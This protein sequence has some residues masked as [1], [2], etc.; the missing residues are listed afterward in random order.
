MIQL[1]ENNAELQEYIPVNTGFS[2]DFLEADID[3][4]LRKYILPYLSRSQFDETFAYQGANQEKQDELLA[5]VKKSTAL[6][7]MHLYM[8]Q[9]KV[10]IDGDSI[11]YSV[12]REKQASA[13]DKRELSDSFLWKG[14]EA[15]EDMLTFLEENDDVFATW[16]GSAGYTKFTDHFVRTATEMKVIE[17]SRL[18][19]L[20]LLPAIEMV[21][22]D[23]AEV[24]PETAF[25]TLKSREFGNDAEQK[26]LWESLLV[27]YVQVIVS[28]RALAMG[29]SQMV[30]HLTKDGK[31]AAFNNTAANMTKGY[32]QLSEARIGQLKG[33]LN[34]QA[35]KRL[36][37]MNQFI[38]DNAELFGYEA[39]ESHNSQPFVNRETH[40]SKF[41][42]SFK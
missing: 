5:L 27:D 10:S 24:L 26:K 33:D 32:L 17:D 2:L 37:R 28:R 35:D 30:V 6:L 22:F 41:F 31:L 19:F 9:A 18:V 8:P 34:Q 20:R 3:S 21:E 42:G 14:L 29:L 36:T 25:D 13:E 40:A 1:F 38:Q 11:T 7:G 12:D 39:P 16:K 23:L 15:V 4:A